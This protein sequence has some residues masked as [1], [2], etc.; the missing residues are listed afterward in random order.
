MCAWLCPT[1]ALSFLSSFFQTCLHV[2]RCRVSAESRTQ[3]RCRPYASWA[4]DAGARVARTRT[5][6]KGKGHA[7]RPLHGK[8]RQVWS[9]TRS[10]WW[11][12]TVRM[13]RRL[14]KS[15]SSR[16]RGERWQNHLEKDSSSRVLDDPLR[17][18]R[19]PTWRRRNQNTGTMEMSSVGRVLEEGRNALEERQDS[20]G[21]R[22]LRA[23]LIGLVTS[24]N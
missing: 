10:T 21:A 24:A 22:C 16:G 19:G 8:P 7:R 6:K 1:S 20:E 23:V 18:W 9:R 5:D 12:P 17:M 14:M 4:E 2:R 15:S 11:T 3:L 13:R